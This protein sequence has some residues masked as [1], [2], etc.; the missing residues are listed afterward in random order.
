MNTLHFK[1]A[2]E[3]DRTCSITQA[4]ENLFMAQ[5]NL[6]KAIKELEESLN[7]TIFT[8]TSKGVSTTEQGREFIKYA[9]NVMA[10]IEKMEALYAPKNE[11]MQSIQISIPRGSYVSD[12]FTRFTKELDHD[13]EID[14]KIHETN[15]MQTIANVTDNA[16]NFGI[17]RCQCVYE[18]YFFDYLAEKNLSHG[19]IWEFDKIV[20]MSKNHP[21]ADSKIKN[22][23]FENLENYTEILYGDKSVPYLSD[24]EMRSH[25]SSNGSCRKIAVYGR[26]SQFDMLTNIPTAYIWESPM[27]ARLLER[28]ELVQKKCIAPN[29]KYKDLLIYPK[30]YKFSELDRRFI[31]KLYTVK[32]EVAFS[33]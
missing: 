9:K 20:L 11:N 19:L 18:N 8:R 16:Y 14:L 21:L 30:D 3:V 12:A 7:I 24:A 2:M 13:K 25:V 28:Y 4:A 31:D 1:Y 17:I 15:A 33:N 10:Q 22:I 27:P 26:C 5:P 23:Q 6:S 32:N 29:K